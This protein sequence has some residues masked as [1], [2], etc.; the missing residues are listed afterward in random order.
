MARQSVV[1]QGHE[2]GS[3]DEHTGEAKAVL[4]VTGV[5]LGADPFRHLGKTCRFP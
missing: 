5:A 2:T 4:I 1:T 3:R